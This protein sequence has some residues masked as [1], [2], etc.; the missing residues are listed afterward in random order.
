MSS[1]PT[2]S[3][4]LHPMGPTK[5]SILHVTSL[6][7]GRCEAEPSAS[8]ISR[9][10]GEDLLTVKPNQCV[11]ISSQAVLPLAEGQ[12]WLDNVYFRFSTSS[13]GEQTVAATPPAPLHLHSG[14]G[15][16]TNVTIQGDGESQVAGF[17]VFPSGSVLM[18]GTWTAMSCLNCRASCCNMRAH[19]LPSPWAS[20]VTITSSVS[21]ACFAEVLLLV[22]SHL[23]QS[24]ST[25]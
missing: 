15:Y 7:Q 9:L 16:I 2:S 12:V 19:E 17:W 21:Q 23:L 25:L 8:F 11:I 5:H 22:S 10:S 3:S 13:I 18:I 24:R 1:G 4:P 14:E 6:P 20:H